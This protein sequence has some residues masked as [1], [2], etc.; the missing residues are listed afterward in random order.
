MKAVSPEP[1]ATCVK[2]SMKKK[3]KEEEKGSCGG[4]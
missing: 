1:A 2:V 3:I 4:L